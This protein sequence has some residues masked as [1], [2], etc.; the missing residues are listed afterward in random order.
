M[1]RKAKRKYQRHPKQTHHQL[2]IGCPTMESAAD[3]MLGV[4]GAGKIPLSI[5]LHQIIDDLAKKTGPSY[6]LD[7]LKRRSPAVMIITHIKGQA[8]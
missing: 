5:P 3:A 4:L 7:D 6:E 2:M 8:K 1:G